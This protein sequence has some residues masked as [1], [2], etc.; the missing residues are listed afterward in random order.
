VILFLIKQQDAKVDVQEDAASLQKALK[1]Y[2]QN[3]KN[4]EKPFII[5][6]DGYDL[7]CIPGTVEKIESDIDGKIRLNVT[8]LFSEL[9]DE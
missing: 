9:E 7:F 4:I 6:L 2:K 3:E 1:L 8:E 5:T